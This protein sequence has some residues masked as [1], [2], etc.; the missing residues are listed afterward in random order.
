MT[1]TGAPSNSCRRLATILLVAAAAFFSKFAQA[2]DSFPGTTLF[3]TAGTVAGTTLGATGQTNENTTYGGGSL[4]TIWYSWTAPSSGVFTANICNQTGESLTTA[5]PTLKVYTGTGFALPVTVAANDDAGGCATTANGGW[6]AVVSFNASAGTVYR[7]QVDGWQSTTGAFTMRWGL[8]A[9]S[10]ST[11][12]ASATEGGD[13]AA[14]TVVL[15]TPPAP[16]PPVNVTTATI[17]N[18]VVTIATSPQCT[19]TPSTLTF[20]SANWGTPQTVT[21]TA[22]D[23]STIEGAHTCSPASIVASGGAYAGIAGPAP[24]FTVNDNENP[25]LTI[26]KAASVSTIAAPGTISYT[27]TVANSGNVPLTSIVITDQLLLGGSGRALTS[28]PTLTS[29][30]TN[31][32]AVL[33]TTETWQFTAGYAVTQADIN[34]GGIFSNVATADSAETA[35]T[36]SSPA[37]TTVFQNPSL[38]LVKSWVF[39]PSGGDA[40]G[41][42][43]ADRNDVIVYTFMVGNTGNVGATSIIINEIFSGQ[44]APPVP[45][46]EVL[47]SDISPTGDSSDLT[48]GDAIWSNLAPGDAVAF[49]AQYTVTQADIDNQ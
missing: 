36:V 19:F 48:P 5:D 22:I 46:N 13:T 39:A 26:S 42:G 24:N 9:L 41:N 21:V 14:F 4:N 17:P 20:T 18:T 35:P 8:A 47:S 6:G 3:G 34:I 30:D 27:M 45:G 10:V 29:G 7:L 16:T 11:T 15:A 43:T 44:G 49:T 32:N 1:K 40:N 38:S 33:D 12:D 31:V 25:A 23:D 28:G 2:S 37:T